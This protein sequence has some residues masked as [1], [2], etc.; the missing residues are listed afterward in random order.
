MT[1]N[2]IDA[3]AGSP[4]SLLAQ[5]PEILKSPDFDLF[6]AY[7]KQDQPFITYLIEYFTQQGLKL[8]LYEEQIDIGEQITERICQG[9]QNSRFVI[10]CLSKH[11]SD[12]LWGRLEYVS[13]II[14]EI[15]AQNPKVLPVIVGEFQEEEM[16]EFLYDKYSVDL[17][18]KQGL[19]RLMRKIHVGAKPDNASARNEVRA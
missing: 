14:Q 4:A 17:R 1:G 19:E 11:F 13:L 15:R 16:P 7:A 12:S 8:W 2:T 6:L 3:S 5:K 9:L 10:L 18:E